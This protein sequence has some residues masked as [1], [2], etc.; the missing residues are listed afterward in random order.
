MT[1]LRWRD[2]PNKIVHV[3]AADQRL[4]DC[5]HTLCGL[6]VYYT[7]QTPYG[8][9]RVELS[10]PPLRLKRPTADFPRPS[11]KLSCLGCLAS[12]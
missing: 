5:V 4:R 11:T 9:V 8:S 3:F 1:M 6:P 2:R 12:V 10:E 7:A